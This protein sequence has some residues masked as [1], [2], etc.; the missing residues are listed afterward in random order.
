MLSRTVPTAAISNSNR[1]VDVVFGME[2][3]PP[4]TA[5]KHFHT[6]GTNKP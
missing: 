3:V 5:M 1:D 4:R 6:V 2:A